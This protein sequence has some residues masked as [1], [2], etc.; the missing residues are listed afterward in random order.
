MRFDSYHPMINLIYFGAAILCT[1][2]FD[3][4]IFLAVSF[5][6]AF[7]YSVKLNG[8]K[9]LVLNLCLVV[10]A[11]AYTAW[12][13]Y[14]HHFGVTSLRVNF[15]GN[16]IT[17]ESVVYGFVRGMTAATMIV[18]FSCIFRLITADKVVYLFGRISPKLSLFLSIL[19]TWTMEDFVESAISMKSRGYSLKGRTAFSIYR[20]D[21]RDRSLVI[22]FFWCLTALL[23]A[24]LFNQTTIYYD[25]VIVMNR[26]TGMSYV[27]Y[28]VYAV[29]LLLPMGL[30]I[31]GELRF[32]K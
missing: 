4:P 7:L 22:V 26:V 8:L 6:C 28:G 19:T 17:L 14:Y 9:S 13:S 21:N 16:Q 3:H 11:V 20:F 12:Y 23:M 24:V 15:I 30:Q 31:V 5:V 32:A 2:C 10:L 1:I 29:F 25:P 18:W 27:F